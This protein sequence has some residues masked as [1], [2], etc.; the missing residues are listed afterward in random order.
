MQ[1]H[2]RKQRAADETEAEVGEFI[3]R[4]AVGC[5]AS[6][7]RRRPLHGGRGSTASPSASNPRHAT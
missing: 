3:P 2:E 7:L 5:T 6:A 1:H 4:H